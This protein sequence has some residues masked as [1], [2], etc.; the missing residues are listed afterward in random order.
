M[1]NHM[2]FKDAE[3]I[4]ILC[5]RKDG[6][7]EEVLIDFKDLE[8]VSKIPGYWGVG[9]TNSVTT[10]CSTLL[11]T[12]K[13]GWRRVYMHRLLCD[14]PVNKEI[15]HYDTNGLNNKRST[16]LRIVTRRQNAAKAR[17]PAKA[18][19]RN[20]LGIRGISLTRNG[21][22]AVTF[23]GKWRGTYLTL[24]GARAHYEALRVATNIMRT[25]RP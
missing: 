11:G 3:T 25:G 19:R 21:R 2:Y 12:R 9:K 8:K 16:N 1:K 7:T 5:N 15:D 10:Y 14:F 4:A 23:G 13:T 17:I 20:K 24:D 6:T 18:T 22:F